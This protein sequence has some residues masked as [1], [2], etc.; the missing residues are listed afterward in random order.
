VREVELS[1]R[2]LAAMAHRGVTA[3]HV[4]PLWCVLP[5]RAA[6]APWSFPGGVPYREL[7]DQRVLARGDRV[8]ID[9]GMLHRGYMS[10]FGCTWVC[11]GEAGPDDRRLRAR[12]QEIVDAALAVCRPGATGADLRRAALAV[13]GSDRPPPWPVPLYLAHGLGLGGVEPPFVG[14]DL[15]IAAEERMVLVPGMVLVLEP[16]IFEEGVGAYR[17]EQTIVITARGFE[18]MSAPPPGPG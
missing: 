7:P 15:G 13:H 16:C 2:F 9:T 8:M 11:G 14:T 1:A 5:R 18:P 3:C 17:A 10:D 12:W 4:E 6:D